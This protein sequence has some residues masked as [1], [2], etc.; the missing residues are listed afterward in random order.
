MAI[1]DY[2]RERFFPHMWCAGCGHG[3][4]LNIML[5]AIEKL[6]MNKNDIVMV[7]GIGC[8]S[9]ISGYVDFHT[10]HTIHGRA[11]A[12]ATGVKMSRPELNILVPMG[13][14]DALA[15]GGN[16]FIHA[17]RRNIGMTLLLLHSEV[18][19]S[20]EQEPLDRMRW[21]SL[22]FQQSIETM[23]TPLEWATA[24][25]AALVG[26]GSLLD[27]DGLAALINEAIET[28][29]FSMIGVTAGADLELGILSRTDWPEHFTAYRRWA[30]SFKDLAVG[31]TALA[32]DSTPPKPTRSVPRYEARIVGLGGQ[33]VKLAGTVLSEAAGLYEG[34]WVTHR[35]EYGSATRGGPSMVDVVASSD[36][37]TYAAADQPDVLVVMSQAG[38]DLY[39]D[40]IKPN[41]SLIAD[42]DQVSSIPSG[43]L[44][45]PIVRL[46][47]EHTGRPIAA[48]VVSLGCVAAVSD[49]VSL[50]SLRQ[51]VA[52]KVPRKTIE[53]NIAALEAGYTATCNVL[54]GETNEK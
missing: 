40:K 23:A 29:G 18:T 16:H 45:V 9:R 22:G 38:V 47:R 11:L 36:R 8:S 32:N 13:D 3:I 7:S 44:T 30:A 48:G 52:Q 27:I 28:P 20:I 12:F 15:I 39:A 35:G 25:Q 26:R 51:S 41:A 49:V 4:V 14:G 17:A 42:S 10:L 19:E 24:L 5:R 21:G 37:I 6:G 2:I 43:A 31:R 53:K 54:K 1:K 46:A 34:L 33:G 50:D